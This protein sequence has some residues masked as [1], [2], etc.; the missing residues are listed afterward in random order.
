MLHFTI[1]VIACYETNVRNRMSRS[2]V[3]VVHQNNMNSTFPG[4]QPIFLQPAYGQ[5][6]PIPG[7]NGQVYYQLATGLMPGQIP[8]QGG[9]Q[10]MYYI[11]VQGP[12]ELNTDVGGGAGIQKPVMSPTSTMISPAG[13]MPGSDTGSLAVLGRQQAPTPTPTPKQELPV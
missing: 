4:G 3:V 8:G 10:Q 11:P 6:Q 5:G 2:T 13:S 7:P 9:Q 1:F 12:T